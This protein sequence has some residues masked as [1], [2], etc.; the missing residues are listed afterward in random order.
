MW[1]HYFIGTD[2]L[3]YVIDSSDI[4][5]MEEAKEEL[6]GILSDIEMKDNPALI[7]CNKADLPNAMSPQQ[8]SEKLGLT[9]NHSI[10]TQR[11]WYCQATIATKG[12]GL[13]EGLDWLCQTLKKIKK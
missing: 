12:E 9:S 3:I 2:A 10:M 11:K 5:R 1:R 8:I 13:I 7:L 4:E 6:W